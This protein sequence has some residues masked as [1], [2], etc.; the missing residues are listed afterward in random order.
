MNIKIKKKLGEGVIGTVYLS[1]I[2]GTESITKVE[3][4][5]GDMT[6]KSNYIRQIDFN[7]FAKQYPDK[8]M[9]LIFHGVIE[10]CKHKQT[11]PDNPNFNKKFLKQLKEKNKFKRCYVLSYVP[12]LDGTLESI[13]YKLTPKQWLN[14]LMQLITSINLMRKAGFHHR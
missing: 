11:L 10:L 6:L 5:D 9:T 3:K 7:N 4:Y 8:F 1:D 12:V 2:D 13:L 14:C